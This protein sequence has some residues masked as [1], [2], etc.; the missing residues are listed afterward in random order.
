MVKASGESWESF[1]R[2]RRD[3]GG[4]TRAQISWRL[5]WAM[6]KVSIMEWISGE[7]AMA[8]MV[9]LG[10]GEERR[11]GGMVRARARCQKVA[12]ASMSVKREPATEAK[13]ALKSAWVWGTGGVGGVASEET[14]RTETPAAA[15][16]ATGQRRVEP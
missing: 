12:L 8:S 9:S 16:S 3:C 10:G 11:A 4:R 13:R 7:A 1:L 2:A 6:R 5:S 15:A 14:S